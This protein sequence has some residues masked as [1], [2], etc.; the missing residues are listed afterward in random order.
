MELTS[1][2]ISHFL[3]ELRE[4]ELGTVGLGHMALQFFYGGPPTNFVIERK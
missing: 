1:A 2:N 4:A 3:L